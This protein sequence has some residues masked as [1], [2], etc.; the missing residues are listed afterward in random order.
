MWK[1][2]EFVKFPVY[3][4]SGGSVNSTFTPYSKS[5]FKWFHNINLHVDQVLWAW[6]YQLFWLWEPIVEFCDTSLK[7]FEEHNWSSLMVLLG[8][9]P[10]VVVT[11]QRETFHLAGGYS[12]YRGEADHLIETGLDIQFVMGVSSWAPALSNFM[13]IDRLPGC[14]K[15]NPSFLRIYWMC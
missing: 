7:L 4:L 8:Y 14:I 10:N 11:W 2:S 13:L 1:F 9:N 12:I 5:Y 6:I 3:Q 15:H